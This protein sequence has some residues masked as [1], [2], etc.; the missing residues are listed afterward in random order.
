MQMLS[1]GPHLGWSEKCQ[2]PEDSASG[3]AKLQETRDR[4]IHVQVE[5]DRTSAPPLY[6]G[7]EG[8]FF[9]FCGYWHLG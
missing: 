6:L 3:K 1:P 8:G 4:I 5:N 9:F 2:A 7:V